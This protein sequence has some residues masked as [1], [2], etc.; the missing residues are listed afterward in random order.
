M[1]KLS[2]LILFVSLFSVA[3]FAKTAKATSSPKQMAA[4]RHYV[5]KQ[6]H[7]AKPAAMEHPI[8][9]ITSCGDVWTGTYDCGSLSE[10]MC[11]EMILFAA[12]LAEAYCP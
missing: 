5:E 3:S 12:D 10:S 1:R 6:L 9:I 2:L 4:T 8:T 7:M 11:N